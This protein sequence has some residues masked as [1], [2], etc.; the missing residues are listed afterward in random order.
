MQTTSKPTLNWLLTGGLMLGLA[1]TSPAAVTRIADSFSLNSTRT[2]G[3]ALGGLTTEVGGATWVASN[4]SFTA[5][6]TIAS[7]TVGWTQPDARVALASMEL[8]PAKGIVTFS[9]DVNPAN[10]GT[11]ADPNAQL[12]G[13]AF[14]STITDGFWGTEPYLLLQ[15]NGNWQF[16][17]NGA[18]ESSGH[19]SD[20]SGFHTLSIS[21]DPAANKIRASV[22]GNTAGW[23]ALG[24]SYTP[25]LGAADIYVQSTLPNATVFQQFDNFVVTVPEPASL[26]L[27]LLAGGLLAGRRRHRN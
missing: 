8:T 24:E 23:S 15:Y 26:G 14:L 12:C 4:C 5:N 19:I 10:N 22:D 20:I 11:E 25:T 16:N 1:A 7:P 2:A 17:V 6:G 9:A 27:L 18:I 3:A 13:I 21:Y